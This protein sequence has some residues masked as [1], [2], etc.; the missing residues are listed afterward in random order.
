M[1]ENCTEYC[2][3]QATSHKSTDLGIYLDSLFLFDMLVT[4]IMIRQFLT[5]LHASTRKHHIWVSRSK[6]LA[7]LQNVTGARPTGMLQM[8][9][10]SITKG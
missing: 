2:D 5:S 7:L 9:V 4:A 10:S 8:R 6:R 1:T 3:K